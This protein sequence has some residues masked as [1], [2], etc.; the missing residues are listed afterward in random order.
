MPDNHEARTDRRDHMAWMACTVSVKH[1]HE[2]KKK[3]DRQSVKCEIVSSRAAKE[4]F[5]SL[6]NSSHPINL[7]I[8]QFELKYGE[9]MQKRNKIITGGFRF[10]KSD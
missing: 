7:S 1:V 6:C 10:F 8:V 4:I 5:V 2:R 9:T 3:I